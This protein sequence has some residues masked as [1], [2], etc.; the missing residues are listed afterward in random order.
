MLCDELMN[1]PS[2]STLVRMKFN[3]ERKRKIEKEKDREEP[4]FISPAL[5]VGEC[6]EVRSSDSALQHKRDTER[7]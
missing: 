7:T 3:K 6:K 5:S 2:N 1:N 4:S